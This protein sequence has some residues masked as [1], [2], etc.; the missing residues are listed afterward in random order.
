MKATRLVVLGVALAT[1]AGAGYM[2]MNMNSQQV[3]EVAAPGEA[4][5]QLELDK[6]LVASAE[7]GIGDVID[8]QVRWQT[9][10]KEAIT[11]GFIAES[12]EAGPW[13]NWQVRLPGWSSCR[14]NQSAVPN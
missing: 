1:A 5:P 13:K 3:V 12:A 6:V 14:A 11:E 7:I 8:G 2:A 9:W 4:K 10:P